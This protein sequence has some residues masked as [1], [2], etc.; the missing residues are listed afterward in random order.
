M[1]FSNPLY[2]PFVPPKNLS[3]REKRKEKEK[4]E[5][6]D[7]PIQVETYMD[8]CTTGTQTAKDI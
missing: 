7:N 5:N 6:C 2:T 1:A 4:K 3:K 8:Q